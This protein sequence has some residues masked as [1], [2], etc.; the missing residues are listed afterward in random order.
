MPGNRGDHGLDLYYK[1]L[2]VPPNCYYYQIRLTVT[3]PSGQ[4]TQALFDNVGLIQWTDWSD[5]L[6][7]IPYPNN[8]YYMQIMTGYRPNH[9]R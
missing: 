8:Y 6:A 5:I 2:S 7:Q 4:T 3:N 9:F 1:E